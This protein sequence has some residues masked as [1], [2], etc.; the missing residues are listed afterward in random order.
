MATRVLLKAPLRQGCLHAFPSHP[1]MVTV[2]QVATLDSSALLIKAALHA[3]IAVLLGPIV[4][5]TIS[6]TYALPGPPPATTKDKRFVSRTRLPC[7]VTVA[8]MA[9]PNASGPEHTVS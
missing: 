6:V 5:A 4:L 7:T 1:L 3:A 9:S 8:E 2:V